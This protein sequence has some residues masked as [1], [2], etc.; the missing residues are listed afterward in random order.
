MLISVLLVWGCGVDRN[1]AK[2]DE[3][4]YQE[5]Q[6]ANCTEMASVL[7]SKLIAKTPENYDQAMKRCQDLKSLSYEEYIR[8]AEASRKSGNWDLYAT[9]PEKRLK[10]NEEPAH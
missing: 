9:Y 2:Y 7:S 5:L 1:A 10:H 3:R 4:R 8:Y 6:R